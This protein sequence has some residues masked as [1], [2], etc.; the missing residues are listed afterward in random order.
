MLKFSSKDII[1]GINALWGELDSIAAF[2]FAK[3]THYI[4]ILKH[5]TKKYK[6]LTDR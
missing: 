6:V 1:Q 4:Y 2:V 5:T 3:L